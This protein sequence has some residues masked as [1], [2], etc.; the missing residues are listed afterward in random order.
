MAGIILKETKL[1]YRVSL[2]ALY[3][4]E[5]YR[6]IASILQSSADRFKVFDLRLSAACVIKLQ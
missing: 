5:Q 3:N 1:L 2:T 6:N 4:Y